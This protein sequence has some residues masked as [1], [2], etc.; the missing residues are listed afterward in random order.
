MTCSSVFVASGSI[1][2]LRSNCRSTDLASEDDFSSA[3]A[4]H[5]PF[6]PPPRLDSPWDTQ[7]SPILSSFSVCSSPHHSLGS[8]LLRSALFCNPLCCPLFLF[9]QSL[10]RSSLPSLAPLISCQLRSALLCSFPHHWLRSSPRSCAS[11]LNPPLLSV[12]SN[13][14]RSVLH[15]A[16]WFAHGSRIFFAQAGSHLGCRTVGVNL[17]LLLSSRS[18]TQVNP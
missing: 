10:L 9:V 14:T 18:I 2:F 17:P 15:S 6:L 5:P 8:S 13:F 11:L 1:C 4:T 7:G 12:L 16:M 3:C